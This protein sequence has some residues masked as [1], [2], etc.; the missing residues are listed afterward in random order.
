MATK[1]KEVNQKPA[2]NF[3]VK[4]LG[5]RYDSILF[6]SLYCLPPFQSLPENWRYVTIGKISQ[7]PA[8]LYTGKGEPTEF[9]F[10]WDLGEAAGI[11]IDT[12]DLVLKKV[13][14]GYYFI[15][16]LAESDEI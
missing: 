9:Q 12:H 7:R 11:T 14:A 16:F 15:F 2:F 10:M 3:S 5:E 13:K 6:N 1:T 8:I 4:S